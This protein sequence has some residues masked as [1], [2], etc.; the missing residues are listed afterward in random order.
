VTVSGLDAGETAIVRIIV[1]LACELNAS[2]TGNILNAIEGAR[3]VDDGTISVGQQ[4]V[5]MKQVGGL[6][7]EPSI[8]VFKDCPA[9]APAGDAV[10]YEITL[11]NTG[12]VDLFNIT[13][14]DDIIGD[15]SSEFPDTLVVGADPVTVQV[16]YTPTPG[17]GDPVTNTITATG[18]WDAGETSDSASD[19][20]ECATDITHAPGI[21]VTKSC[22][23]SLAFGADISF[24]ITV[25][26]TG[27]EALE[28]VLLSD[29][30][31]DGDITGAFDFPDPFPV[32][33]RA[34]ADLTYTPGAD[35]DPVANSV[36]ASG[37]G[38]D[39]EVGVADTAVC[40]SDVSNPGISILKTVDEEV[41]PIGT[42]VTFTYVITNTGDVT[43][44]D[45]V[46]EDDI[47]GRVGI[48]AEL[49][50]GHSATLTKDF[51]VG[52]E[53]VTN[54]GTAMGHDILGREV[55]ASDD[56]TVAPIAGENP[57]PPNNPPTP[58]TGSD[59]GRL[60]LITMV[61][62]GLGVTVVAS[63]RRRRPK[64]EA[65]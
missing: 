52:D 54:V 53:I 63:T 3:V 30:L 47:L 1:H 42:T 58:F 27:N 4:T 10:T 49:E 39:S 65:A 24:T 23:A 32:G 15:L 20:A 6:Q 38:V 13:V 40:T 5:P 50:P 57:P 7:A 41:V 28:N 33:G 31:L 26:N 8:D 11:R 14:V 19:T 59:A 12:N 22:P 36:T 56:A 2:P 37:D 29:A 48:I 35:Q 60:G 44:F 64:G 55:S 61:L 25:T 18:D 46:V 17:D 34:S 43:L 62:F 9:I 45:I 51:V 16:E 21:D